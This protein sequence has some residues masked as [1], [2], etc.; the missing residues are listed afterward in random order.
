MVVEIGPGVT[1]FK[2]GDRILTWTGSFLLG[3]PDGGAFQNYSIAKAILTAKIP[4]TLTLADAAVIPLGI[5][6]AAA[7]IFDS[8][9]IALPKSDAIAKESAVLLVW[10]GSSSVGSNAI[11]LGHRLGFAVITTA[12]PSHHEYLKSLGATAVFDY[13]SPSVVDDIAAAVKKTGRKLAHALDAISLPDSIQ[14]TVGVLQKAGEKGSKIG[15]VLG[16]PV[17]LPKP[18]GVEVVQVGARNVLTKPEL[19]KWLFA[20]FI[21]KSLIKGTFVPSPKLELLSGG[22]DG[23]QDGLDRLKKGASGQ[24]FVAKLS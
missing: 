19:A 20:E 7:G 23:L 15:L 10:G 14:G 22:L 2:E 5:V 8:L 17:D 6:T 9:G 18:D 12:S 13:H 11:Q 16:W 21:T 1:D 3:S 24:K 4:D